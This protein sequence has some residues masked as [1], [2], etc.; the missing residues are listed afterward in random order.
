MKKILSVLCAAILLVGLL[1]M[2]AAATGGTDFSLGT[3]VTAVDGSSAAR[4][5]N[6]LRAGDT[7]TV[8]VTIPAGEA[9]CSAGVH[10]TFDNTKFE[11]TGVASGNAISESDGWSPA[12]VSAPAEANTNGYAGIAAVYSNGTSNATTGSGSPTLC[13][14]TF[15]VK[16][17]GSGTASF[18][19]DTIQIGYLPSDTTNATL[20]T[21]G[22]PSAV[23]VTILTEISS[24]SLSALNIDFDQTAVTTVSG[25]G[26]TGSVSWSGVTGGGTISQAGTYTATI[27]LSL[28][29]PTASLPPPPRSPT[30]VRY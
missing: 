14:A 13:T 27:I 21:V 20:Y 3:S 11:C 15:T 24:V 23:S 9:I 2:T 5:L 17:G 4:S 22:A 16:S 29:A 10:V 19:V 18:G 25:T 1:P 26:C 8:E 30:A 28:P 12:T 6:S 7:V